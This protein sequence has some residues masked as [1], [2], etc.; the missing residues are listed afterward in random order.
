MYEDVIVD[1]ET[2]NQGG[3]RLVNARK[4][5]DQDYQFVAAFY[6]TSSERLK[7]P[8]CTAV[9]ITPDFILT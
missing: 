8:T 5:T 4:M 6:L 9:L 1:E 2:A 7:T 3:S